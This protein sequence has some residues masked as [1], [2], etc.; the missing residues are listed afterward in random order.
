ML[1][2][3]PPCGDSIC[4]IDDVDVAVKKVFL[5]FGLDGAEDNRQT[6]RR[7]RMKHDKAVFRNTTVLSSCPDEERTVLQSTTVL[8]RASDEDQA[9]FANMAVYSENS[10]K[11]EPPQIFAKPL[12]LNDYPSLGLSKNTSFVDF[13]RLYFL[14]WH[15]REQGRVEPLLPEHN[16]ALNMVLANRNR[17]CRTWTLT[18]VTG[19]KAS[20]LVLFPIPVTL[21]MRSL[22]CLEFLMM[23]SICLLD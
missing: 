16:T 23:L 4:R 8:T 18:I 17:T 15:P 10:E 14:Q 11:V 22:T 2:K 13:H 20:A 21:I 7:N 19:M 9:V 5:S 6:K 3:Y 12:Q 1:L